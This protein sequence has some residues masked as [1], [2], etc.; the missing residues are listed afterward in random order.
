MFSET[1]LK[2]GMVKDGLVKQIRTYLET[3]VI[4]CEMLPGEKSGEA[5]PRF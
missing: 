4:L 1:L 5:I 2:H 3:E